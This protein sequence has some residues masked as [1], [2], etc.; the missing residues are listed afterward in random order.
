MG[1]FLL[2]ER[3]KGKR[4]PSMCWGLLV[5]RLLQIMGHYWQGDLFF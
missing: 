1:D 5:V 3:S 2:L 4:S